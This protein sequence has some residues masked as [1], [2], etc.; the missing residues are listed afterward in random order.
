MDL[1][2]I[3]PQ[4]DI[5]INQTLICLN[6]CSINTFDPKDMTLSLKIDSNMTQN[7]NFKIKF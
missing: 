3:I 4:L 1:K 6:S 2:V 7:R 5:T